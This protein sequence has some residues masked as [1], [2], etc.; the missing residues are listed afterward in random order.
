[1]KEEKRN[2]MER[3][4][5]NVYTEKVMTEEEVIF[6]SMKIWNESNHYS[7]MQRRRL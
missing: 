1:L 3:R 5:N 2:Q 6:W 4:R 7:E